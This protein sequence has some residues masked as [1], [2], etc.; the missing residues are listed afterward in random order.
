[1]RSRK[2][3]IKAGQNFM[4][5]CPLTNFKIAQQTFVLMEASWRLLENFFRL[6]L[7]KMS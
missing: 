3:T 7:Q 6:R 2:E 5:P 1:M 4:L